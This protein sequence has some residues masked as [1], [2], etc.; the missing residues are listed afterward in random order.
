MWTTYSTLLSKVL[1]EN[2]MDRT[3]D[4]H[5]DQNSR[6]IQQLILDNV[7]DIRKRN[8]AM[9]FHYLPIRVSARLGTAV[10]DV[11]VKASLLIYSFRF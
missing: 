5:V 3:N 6:D 10:S 8:E 7:S 11:K 2:M 9:L 4:Q 1:A